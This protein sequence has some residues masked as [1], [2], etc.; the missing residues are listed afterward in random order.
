MR[1]IAQNQIF[2]LSVQTMNRYH[3]FY[4]DDVVASAAQALS[5]ITSTEYFATY[6]DDI[7]APEFAVE[8]LTFED[9]VL[10]PLID[11]HAHLRAKCR[12]LL[13][14]IHTIRRRMGRI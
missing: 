11:K 4:G 6:Q 2:M 10:Q 7:V 14:A 1:D 5:L 3:G 12:S 13:D 8:L 9:D